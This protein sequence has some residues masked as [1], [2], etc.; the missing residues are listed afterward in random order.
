MRWA[1]FVGWILSWV[2]GILLLV[3]GVLMFAGIFPPFT[4]LG[5]VIGAIGVLQLIIVSYFWP[6]DAFK[7]RRITRESLEPRRPAE[8][9]EAGEP[10]ELPRPAE[11]G[12]GD[13]RV[14]A[15]VARILDRMLRML[16]WGLAVLMIGWG[17]LAQVRL[18][19]HPG[20]WILLQVPLLILALHLR[21]QRARR[22][23]PIPWEALD[24]SPPG[25]SA[26]PRAGDRRNNGQRG[27][28]LISTL[29]ALAIITLCLTM[30]LQAYVHGSRFVAIE[31]RRTQAIAACQEQVELARA[32][33]YAGLPAIGSHTFGPAGEAP[34]QGEVV[35]A[36]GPV[37]G[38][39]QV[40][41]RVSWAAGEEVPAGKVE[42]VTVMSARGISP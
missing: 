6:Q 5:G 1:A 29:V 15:L 21:R 3:A 42:L 33:G 31:A 23:P 12:E 13:R 41:A 9:R 37:A 28:T 10:L 17:L 8:P 35:V 11:R 26:E 30:F 14:A 22:A 40:T 39:K 34:L 32:R 38:S 4:T 7:E 36:D 27:A 25:P 19:P 2:I 24:P 16:F 20:G 18:V